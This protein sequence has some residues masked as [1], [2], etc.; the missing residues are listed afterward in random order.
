MEESK[1]FE[2]ENEN[3]DDIELIETEGTEVETDEEGVGFGGL[4]LIGGVLA[5]VAALGV[6][7]YKKFK[8]KKDGKP[9]VKKRLKWVE[10]DENDVAVVDVKDETDDDVEE[11]E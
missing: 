3:M 10:V 7:A 9:K 5:G 8:A 1:V 2:N 11:N 6:H 4:A